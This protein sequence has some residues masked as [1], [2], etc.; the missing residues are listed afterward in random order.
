MVSLILC[1]KAGT[2]FSISVE[3]K[4]LHAPYQT[5]LHTG[6]ITIYDCIKA[7]EV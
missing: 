5:A 7:V 4:Q 3:Y 1:L 6:C 2:V